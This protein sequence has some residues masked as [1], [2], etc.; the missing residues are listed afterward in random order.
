[1]RTS[2]SG[3]QVTSTKQAVHEME[4]EGKLADAGSELQLVVGH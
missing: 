3:L 2:G 4:K 1:M